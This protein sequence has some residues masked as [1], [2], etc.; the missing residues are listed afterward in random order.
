MAEPPRRVDLRLTIPTAAPYRNVA[1]EITEKFAEYAGAKTAAA[2]A[3]AASIGEA[4]AP[5][6]DAQPDKPID[7]E[8]SA[9]DHELVVT[10]N[11]GTTTKRA[12]CPL[13]D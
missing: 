8:M 2:K 13:P 11:S 3:F 7:L 5:A 9:Q 10:A 12:T 1:V 4:I 6:A